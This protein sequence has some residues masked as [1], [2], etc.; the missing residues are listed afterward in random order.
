MLIRS[1]PAEER[2]LEKAELQGINALSS[3]ELIALILR[4]GTRDISAVTLASDI[5]A[6]CENGLGD[7][8]SMDFGDLTVIR[9]IGKSKAAAVLAAVELGKRIASS[10]RL[11]NHVIQ[12]SQ[13]A[14]HVF[15][16]RLRYEKK[17]HF[18]SV[19]LSTKG[20]I[21]GMGEVSIGDLSGTIV[22]P[23]EVFLE[24]V[25]KSAASV[26]FIHNHPSGDPTP[27][28][29]DRSTNDRLVWAGQILGIDVLDHIIIG[30]GIYCSF[31][32]LGYMHE[33]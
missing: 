3:S 1:L 9:G 6:A 17:E 20:E 18:I 2:P 33:A 24:A 10:R 27:S 12:S 26:V 28:R 5:V 25:K 11:G 4:T 30:D 23:R 31:R 8:A 19:P 7:L 21:L 16:E 15:M 29:Q 14:A 32:A 22:N 13:D